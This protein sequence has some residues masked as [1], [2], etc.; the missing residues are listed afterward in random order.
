MFSELGDSGFRNVVVIDQAQ[1]KTRIR[2]SD[3]SVRASGAGRVQVR[4]AGFGGAEIEDAVGVQEIGIRVTFNS[5]FPTE[6]IGMVVS[7]PRQVGVEVGLFL[8]RELLAIDAAAHPQVTR[9]AGVVSSR[10]RREYRKLE[11]REWPF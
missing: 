1:Q 6:L 9:A 8:Q 3:G 5:R 4:E 10:H 7:D 2:K 11:R